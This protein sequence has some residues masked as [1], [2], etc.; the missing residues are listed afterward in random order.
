[1]SLTYV[2]PMYHCLKK[3]T[4]DKLTRYAVFVIARVFTHFLDFLNFWADFWFA[5]WFADVDE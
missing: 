4:T 3:N 2:A 5:S 1:M